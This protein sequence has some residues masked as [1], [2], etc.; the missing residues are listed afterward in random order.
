MA[1]LLTGDK[2]RI[3]PRRSPSDYRFGRAHGKPAGFPARTALGRVNSYFKNMIEAV[4]NAKLRRMQRELERGGVGF[5][6]AQSWPAGR[7]RASK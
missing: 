7:S 4:A 1:H 3:T 5:A 2:Y 6:R